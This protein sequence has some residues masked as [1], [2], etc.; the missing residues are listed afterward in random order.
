[1]S[2]DA[3]VEALRSIWTVMAA[4]AGELTAHHATHGRWLDLRRFLIRGCP[5]AMF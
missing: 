4:V 1:M 3:A 5:Q 2:D